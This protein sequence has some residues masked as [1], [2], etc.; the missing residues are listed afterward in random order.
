MDLDF[1]TSPGT[2]IISMIKYLLQKIIDEFS[3]VLRGTK[4]WPVGDNLFKVRDNEDREILSGEMTKKLYCTVAQ[5][6][7]L[8]K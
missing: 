4:A 2:M 8:C 5:L 1:R 7:F 6:L 3:E